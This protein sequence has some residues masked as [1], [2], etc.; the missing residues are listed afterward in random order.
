MH[1][2]GSDFQL[3]GE[4]CIMSLSLKC[5]IFLFF[6]SDLSTPKWKMFTGLRIEWK[7]RVRLNNLIWRAWFSEFVLGRK[8][9]FCYFSVQNRSE[10]R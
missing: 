4:S 1:Y 5:I 6:F 10:N 2:R 7:D 8:P 9:K 3:H